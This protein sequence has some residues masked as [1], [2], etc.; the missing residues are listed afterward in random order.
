MQSGPS[1]QLWEFVE[2]YFQANSKENRIKIKTQENNQKRKFTFYRVKDTIYHAIGFMG[3]GAGLTAKVKELEND[4]GAPLAVKTLGGKGYEALSDVSNVD[5]EQEVMEHL[6]KLKAVHVRLLEAP[7]P[8]IRQKTR[9][10]LYRR[11]WERLSSLGGYSPDELHQ[12]SIIQNGVISNKRLY[13]FMEKCQGMTL[14]AL[15]QE[16]FAGKRV[17]SE[18]QLLNIAQGC[19]KALLDMHIKLTIHCDLKPEHFFVLLKSDDKCEVELIDHGF[20]LLL[21]HKDEVRTID[22]ARGTY[23]YIPPESKSCEYSVK[24]DIYSLGRVFYI[25]KNLNGLIANLATNMQ[26]H[27][28]ARRMTLEVVILTLEELIAPLEKKKLETAEQAVTKQ[29]NGLSF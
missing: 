17:L 4:V 25:M 29:M 5:E 9:D 16:V 27:N 3:F 23:S 28:P 13:Y 26:K 10:L 21:K 8:L 6:L 20:S 14:F 18:L 22:V 1:K 24:G 12:G 7:K 2:S 15:L 11:E 19:A